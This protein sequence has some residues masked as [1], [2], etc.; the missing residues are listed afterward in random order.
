MKNEVNSLMGLHFNKWGGSYTNWNNSINTMLTF[1]TS[2]RQIAR[3]HIQ[4]EFNLTNQVDIELDVSPA[5]AGKIKISTVTPD[6]LPW[7]GVYFNGVPVRITAY[8]NSGYKFSHWSSNT[9]EEKT[10]SFE[11]NVEQDEKFIAHFEKTEFDFQVFPNPV[12]DKLTV[13]YELSSEMKVNINVYSIDGRLAASIVNSE[14]QKEG[15]HSVP[16]SFR[17]NGLANGMYFIKI[18]AGEDSRTV[19]ITK[20]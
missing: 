7:K 8:S 13:N 15:E 10:E 17:G 1:N 5:G 4:A 9:T 2:R 3:N 14:V 16:F 18:D 6:S 20:Q 11:R 19:K 12:N